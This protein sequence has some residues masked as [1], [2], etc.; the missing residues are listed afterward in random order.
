MTKKFTQ[1]QIELLRRFKRTESRRY[2]SPHATQSQTETE[3]FNSTSESI[4]DK[5]RALAARCSAILKSGGGPNG[6]T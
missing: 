3:N 4:S 6:K 5:L 2:A 1:S